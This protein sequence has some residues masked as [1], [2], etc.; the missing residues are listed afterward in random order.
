MQGH[1]KAQ[2]TASRDPKQNQQR[3]CCV[4]QCLKYPPMAM[5][6][7]GMA[8]MAMDVCMCLCGCVWVS[9]H[10][11]VCQCSRGCVQAER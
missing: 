5:G 3:K 7:A 6:D 10:G 4:R 8:I 11:C 9:V 2:K 1:R